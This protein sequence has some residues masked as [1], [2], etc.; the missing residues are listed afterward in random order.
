M[1][2]CI[3]VAIVLLG[4]LAAAASAVDERA[5]LI[6]IA[7]QLQ[8]PSYS[9]GCMSNWNNATPVCNFTGVACT[10]VGNVARLG[11]FDCNLAG[12][13]PANLSLL[14]ELQHVDLS[15]NAVT[16]SLPREWGINMTALQH[17]D[18]SLNQLSGSL[19]PEWGN[20]AV[21]QQLDLNNNQLTGPLP[22]EWG[23][24]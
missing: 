21:L 24:G 18:L 9:G 12:S 8:G 17:L 5:L 13:L 1:Y 2:R 4:A 11:L 19:P 15:F 3:A 14:G 23:R 22:P 20:M 10:G 6:S 7:S 16:G